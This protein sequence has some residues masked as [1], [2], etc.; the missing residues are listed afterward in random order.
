LTSESTQQPIIN[1]RHCC[2]QLITS[3]LT[4]PPP[5]HQ[6]LCHTS[7]LTCTDCFSLCWR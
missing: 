1:V 5:A 7:R 2:A 4:F 3:R 6:T